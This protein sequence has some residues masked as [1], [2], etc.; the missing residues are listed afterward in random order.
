MS[1]NFSPP[2]GGGSS[3]PQAHDPYAADRALAEW[4]S[5]RSYAL[6]STPDITSYKAWYPCTYM[7]AIA[8]VG[9]ALFASFGEANVAGVETFSGDILLQATGDDR[10]LIFFLLSPRLTARSA[11]RS[12]QGGGFVNEISSGLGSLFGSGGAPGS[13]LGDPTFEKPF[14]ITAPSRDEGNKALPM[15]LRRLLLTSN[16]RG[17][18]ETR[19]GGLV[20]TMYDRR[21]FDPQALDAAINMLGQIYNAAIA[22]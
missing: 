1:Q 17:V 19:Q 22:E 18:L 9:R 8:R 16:F 13:I 3:A 14:D 21:T 15:P 6:S 11:I 10:N 2:P 5:S 12:K 7:P 20:C 4:A